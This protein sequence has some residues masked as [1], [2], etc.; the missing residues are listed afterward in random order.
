[1]LKEKTKFK[2]T[3]IGLIPEEWDIK[4]IDG[5]CET[6]FSGGT[7]NTQIPHYWNG[8]LPWLSSGETNN[9]FIYTTEKYITKY[10]A[11]NSSTRMAKKGDIV[12]ASAGQG[13]TRGQTSYCLID[14]YVNQSLIC[15]RANSCNDSRWL[16]Y[17]LSNRYDELRFISESNSS[18][19]S[20][21]TKIIK[22]IL[23]TCPALNEQKAIAAVLSSLD[24]KIELLR[25]QNKTLEAIARALFKEWFIDFNFPDDNGKPYEKFGGKM[26][27]SE[28][29]EIPEEWRVDNL[30]KYIE[31][32]GGGTPSTKRIEFW[33]GNINWTSPKDLSESKEI[34]LRKTNK[35]ITQEGLNSIS[36]GLLPIETLL[37][38]SRAPI[39]YLALASIETAI[40]QGYIAFLPGAY[41][42]NNFMY[43]W[44]KQN[45]ERVLNAANGSTFLEISKSAFKK[46]DSIIPNRRVLD[47]FDLIVKSI[48]E[49]ILLNLEEIDSLSLYRDKLLPKLM[50]GEIRVKKLNFSDE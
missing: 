9:Q 10:G 50:K 41:L 8:D 18:R 1:M 4:R 17:N 12:I 13:H 31:I 3:D 25:E 40:N 22:D 48:F 36:S 42:S 26:T 7:P 32:K 28:L 34:F 6:I 39:G 37:L 29:G 49:K 2:E 46:I 19:G 43:L 16:F 33:G 11:Q 45:M 14:T 15:L 44:L 27:D 23:I 38:S 21:T 24:D 5:I 47:S 35:K 20:L 30:E